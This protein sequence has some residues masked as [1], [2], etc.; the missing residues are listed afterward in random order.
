MVLPTATPLYC[1]L[2]FTLLGNL[3]PR[4]LVSLALMLEEVLRLTQQCW[5]SGRIA[6]G[7]R[8][9][10]QQALEAGRFGVSS[11]EVRRMLLLVWFVVVL[12]FWERQL[13]AME[14]GLRHRID[15][16]EAL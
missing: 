6:Q 12:V 7:L 14:R 11:L 4:V 16:D 15:L 1:M 5:P 8:N 3:Q 13:G 2:A 10:E 9:L